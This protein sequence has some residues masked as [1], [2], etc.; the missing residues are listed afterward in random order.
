MAKKINLFDTTLRDGEQAPGIHLNVREKLEIAEQL[1]RLNVDI[2]EAGFPISSKSDFNSVVEISK[3]I[4]NRRIAALAR[5]V[6]IDID[7]AGEA[8]QHAANPVIHTFISSSDIHLEYQFKKT[9]DEAI[10]LAADAVKRARKYTDWVEFSAM[11]ATRSDRDFLCRMYE[12][13]IK[14]GA[15]VLNVPDTVGYA[16]PEE[17]ARLIDYI[18]ANTA[19]IENVIISVHCHNDLGLAVANSILAVQH[20]AGQIEVSVNGI[21]ERAGNAAFE[22]IA[23]VLDTRKNELDFY[24]DINLKEI[25]KT[26]MLVRHLTGYTVAPNKP[27]VGKY[28]FTHEAGIHQDG[29]LKNRTTYE[30]MKPEDIGSQPSKLM[31]GKHSGRHAFV[32]R[33]EELGFRL[34]EDEIEKAFEGFKD[35][36]EKK[37]EIS[38]DDLKAIINNEIRDIEEYFK[39]KYYQVINGTSIK[40]TATVGIEV[41]GNLIESAS[42]GDGP[43]D[44]SFKAI[45]NI[46]GL[47]A[48][49]SDYSI[50]AVSEG[51]DAIGSVKVILNSGQVRVMGSGISTDVIEASIKSYLDALNR[52]MLYRKSE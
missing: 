1:D 31:L 24:T 49:L 26:S 46:T 36:A 13:A 47:E 7:T 18:I 32:K 6:P 22:E 45:D 41:N 37:G 25:M 38:D 42:Y 17:Y 20:G 8:L 12:A 48:S 5:A 16:L 9:R 14:S 28:V 15:S 27:I 51:G 35:L 21:G 19:G 52:I 11:D 39:L 2:I 10:V 29:M 34:S 44:A 43:V 33:I 4:K 30:I 3:K 50:E 40:S 23:M